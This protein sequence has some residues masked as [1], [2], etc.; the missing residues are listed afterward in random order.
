MA[1][2][3]PTPK[4]P[5]LIIHQS[6][7]KKSSLGFKPTKITT[8]MKFHRRKTKPRNVNSKVVKWRKWSK[9]INPRNS[10]EILA[11]AS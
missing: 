2:S 8:I 5:N 3:A 4:H 11:V 9:V 1:V 7:N 6:N 10:K